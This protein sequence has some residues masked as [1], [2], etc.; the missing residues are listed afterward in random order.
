MDQLECV[1][2]LIDLINEHKLNIHHDDE[3]DFLK[4]LRFLRAR[5]FHVQNSFDFL[6]ADIEWRQSPQYERI[7]K[8][9]ANDILGCEVENIFRFFPTWISGVDKQ[10]RPISWRQFGKFEIWFAY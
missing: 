10:S 2:D 1:N 7:R 3:D 5:R 9:S 6:K 4:L 8:L